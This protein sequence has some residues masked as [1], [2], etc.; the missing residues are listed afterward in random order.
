MG[1]DVQVVRS[2]R[3]EHPDG[4]IER[5]KVMRVPESEKFP[6]GI[7]YR[8]HHTAT[9]SDPEFRYDN[10]HGVHEV[11]VGDTTRE[12]VYPGVAELFRRFSRTVSRRLGTNYTDVT[13]EE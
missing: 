12:I 10:S 5:V 6:E 13:T 4:S 2:Y 3:R 9:A 7:K 8:M 1:D 11:H